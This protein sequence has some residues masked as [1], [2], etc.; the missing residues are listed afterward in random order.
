MQTR[1]TDRDDLGQFNANTN[2]VVQSLQ[3]V[4]GGT[5][6]L[7]AYWNGRVFYGGVRDN[8]KALPLT[9][10]QLAIRVLRGDLDESLS[11]HPTAI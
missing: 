2:D 9:N 8:V 4:I 5:W 3:Q 10:G 7:P 6:S 11:I 1:L